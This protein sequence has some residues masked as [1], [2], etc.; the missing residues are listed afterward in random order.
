[1]G[2]IFESFEGFKRLK[3]LNK[4]TVNE[5][6]E[7]IKNFS[8]S[9]GHPE[10]EKIKGKT[11]IKFHEDI[12]KYDLLVEVNKNQI[13]IYREREESFSNIKSGEKIENIFSEA[14]SSNEVK[15][16]RAVEE[17]AK[18]IEQIIN[19]EEITNFEK[20]EIKKYI[21]KRE[22]IYAFKSWMKGKEYGVYEENDKKYVITKSFREN[23]IDFIQEFSK[24]T[25]FSARFDKKQNLYSLNNYATSFAKIKF[26]ENGTSICEY[27]KEKN[28]RNYVLEEL[29]IIPD[30]TKLHYTIKLKNSIIACVDTIKLAVDS[31]YNIEI[32]DKDYE[33]VVLGIA[34]VIEKY[35][36]KKDDLKGE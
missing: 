21:L 27:E 35:I 23:R 4:I 33:Y 25:L 10:L 24:R 7:K 1:M 34:M 17:V 2:D 14:K 26:Q 18:I 32:R 9:F 29:K 3:N 11:V 6:F 36:G 5:L 12:K 20:K 19:G 16:N 22:R 28:T 31:Q 30:N 8:F 13:I 15:I